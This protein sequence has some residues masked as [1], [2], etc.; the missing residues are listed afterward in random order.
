MNKAILIGNVGRDPEV[1]TTQLGKRLANMSLAT[2]ESWRDKQTGERRER[3]EWHRIVVW[4]EGL[5]NVIDRYVR[6]GDK[7]CVVGQI[8]TRKWQDQSGADRYSTEIVL[9]GYQAELHMLGSPGGRQD[10]R[11]S[12]TPASDT[13][14]ADRGAPDLDDDIPF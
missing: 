10:N 4:N 12:S 5:V 1:K 13:E 14:T 8:Q 11:T 3:T 7:L 2:S 9:Q 6:K